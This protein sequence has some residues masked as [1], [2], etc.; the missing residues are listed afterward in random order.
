MP[1]YC[2]NNLPAYKPVIILFDNK[3]ETKGRYVFKPVIRLVR[4]IGKENMNK[5]GKMNEQKNEALWFL[6]KRYANK[7]RV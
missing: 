3:L 5:P 1:A 4:G 2:K 7:N 6:H